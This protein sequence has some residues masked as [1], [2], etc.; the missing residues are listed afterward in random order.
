[1][2]YINILRGE[3]RRVLGEKGIYFLFLFLFAMHLL[4][5]YVYIE[6]DTVD[7][8]RYRETKEQVFSMTGQ[9]QEAYLAAEAENTEEAWFL[10]EEWMTAEQYPEFLKNVEQQAEKEKGILIFNK[11]SY[12]IRNI[13]KTE[14][15]Y[16]S[17]EGTELTLTGSYG[18][19]RLFSFPVI[20]LLMLIFICYLVIIL[21]LDDK[22]S[23][24]LHLFKTTRN[25][26]LPLGLAKMNVLLIASFM[27][28]ILFY[29]SGILY[30]W[31][32]YGKVPLKAS[33]QSLYGFECSTYKTSIGVFLCFYV[34]LKGLV[35]MLCGIIFYALGNFFQNVIYYFATIAGIAVVSGSLF[36]L[37]SHIGRVEMLK[38]FN[39]V[40]FFDTGS[41]YA[42]YYNYN[43]FGFPCSLSKVNFTG[44]LLA[45]IISAILGIYCF[46]RFAYDY[47][48]VNLQI[49]SGRRVKRINIFKIEHY[50]LFYGNRVFIFLFAII[51]LQGY[52]YWGKTPNWFKD[53]LYY[54]KYVKTIEGSCNEEK[55]A[56]LEEELQHIEKT[57]QQYD[58]LEQRYCAGEVGK[59]RY[60]KE[61]EVYLKEIE[62]KNGLVNAIAYADYIRELDSPEK[63]FVYDRGWNY[64]GGTDH[65][66]NDIKNS[67]MLVLCIIVSVSGLMAQ[68]YQY[69]MQELLSVYKER[70]R[71]KRDKCII[72]VEVITIFFMIIYLPEYLW[73]WNNFTLEGGD[74]TIKSL[75]LFSG[76]W[77]SGSIKAYF[78]CMYSIRYVTAL[79]VGGACVL[80]GRILKNTN[81]TILIGGILFLLPL[82]IHLLGV[83]WI[84]KI[85]LNAFLSGNMFLRR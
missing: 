71:V 59:N 56:Y 75:S 83:E 51:L 33:L 20:D 60:E 32:L 80:L 53:Q 8:G 34:L 70:N 3:M 49:H 23:G 42:H 85:S 78:L 74:F 7:A 65:Y 79:L 25:G 40:Y 11:N 31:V 58:E 57:E 68:E 10:Y 67:I 69:E 39:L 66:S 2:Q 1:M 4:L 48:R 72:M 26:G 17:M 24:I 13:L 21:V 84:D 30:V 54:R 52:L 36:F 37:G 55:Y 6:N 27:A 82:L 62:A 12:T 41:M 50:K 29:G 14:A 61:K 18:L 28:T 35:N 22:K 64:L 19:W 38:Y 45:I 76:T 9:E 77:F 44:I 43:L 46:V 16:A 63:G 81:R 73:V 15:D 5:L 47:K